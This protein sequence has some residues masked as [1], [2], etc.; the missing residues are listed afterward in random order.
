[1]TPDREG[2]LERICQA[3]LELPVADV[4]TFSS[5]RAAVTKDSVVRPRRCW[6]KTA[7]PRRFSR[8]LRWRWRRRA[9]TQA[10]PLLPASSSAPTRSS[11]GSGRAAW[12][13]STGRATP[14]SVATSRS[15]F[16]PLFTSDPE[17]LARFE[18][19]ARLLASLNHPNIATIHG[20]EHM[21]GI[22]ALVLE[23][24]EGETLAERL[25]RA[26]PGSSSGNAA[27]E[28]LTIARQI[29][30][31]LEAAHEQGIVHRDLKPA[32]IKIRPDGVVKVLD[33]G[34]AKAAARDG[35][36][37]GRVAGTHA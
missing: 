22:H 25:H 21:D 32:N 18:R 19:E 15:K 1:M 20:V 35:S 9:G 3:A 24:V 33:F 12:A 36:A 37:R 17:R 28:A 7:R 2:D 26:R 31:A 27:A 11:P 10:P 4:P 34:L 5:R 16:S 14:R 8:H 30:E 13:R 6:R 29:A 23:L